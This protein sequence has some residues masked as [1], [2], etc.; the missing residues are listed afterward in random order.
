MKNARVVLVLY[1][2]L[3]DLCLP[4][5]CVVCGKVEIWLCENCASQISFLGANI[6]PRCGRPWFVK[7]TCHHCLTA[8]VSVA[9]VRSAYLYDGPVRDAIHAYKFR[10]A[11]SLCVLLAQQMVQ[12][13]KFYAIHSDVLVPVP[14]HPERE[15]QRGY[16]QAALLARELGRELN[17]PVVEDELV[18]TRNTASQTHLSREERLKNV[19]GAFA[20]KTQ[21]RF[22][23]KRVT[24]IDDVATTGATLNACALALL[25]YGAE[26]V[27]AFTLARA[28]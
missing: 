28:A 9:P 4:P 20:C 5:C 27:G 19:A 11:R 25:A 16:N 3:L 18:R 14:L 17:V 22:A 8:P 21:H 1:R 6:C 13:W 23:G 26:R 12:A 15:Q 10:G 7:G 24:L 2:W